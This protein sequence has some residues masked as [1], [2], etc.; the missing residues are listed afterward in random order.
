MAEVSGD[1]TN[2]DVEIV[3]SGWEVGAD[4]SKELFADE[5]FSIEALRRFSFEDV[6]K[7]I[8]KKAKESPPAKPTDPQ[9]SP[10]G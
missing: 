5:R 8:A 2:A 3:F 4:V 6:R 7:S 1:G 9:R 10:P